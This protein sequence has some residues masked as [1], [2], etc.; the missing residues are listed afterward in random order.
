MKTLIFEHLDVED[1]ETAELLQTSGG[2]WAK[3]ALAA[4]GVG[5]QLYKFGWD[6]GREYARNH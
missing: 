5:Y 4:I 3:A 1:L 6:L 2:I